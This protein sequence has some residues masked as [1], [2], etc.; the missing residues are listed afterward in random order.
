[1]KIEDLRT[2]DDKGLLLRRQDIVGELTSLKFQH[3]T[4]QLDDTTSIKRLRR[5]LAR[6]NTIIRQRE[7]EGG[8][9]KGSLAAKVGKLDESQ[10][11]FAAFRERF[12][13]APAENG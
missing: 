8:L 5:S 12:N 9:V 3:A 10:S 2:L 13:A 11:A 7:V 4:G 6:V 1:M